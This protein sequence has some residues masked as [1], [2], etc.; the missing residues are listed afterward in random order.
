MLEIN[1]YT[2]RSLIDKRIKGEP[3][4]IETRNKSSNWRK[5]LVEQRK[6]FYKDLINY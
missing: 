6:G 1:R 4:L 2:L 3:L 5:D